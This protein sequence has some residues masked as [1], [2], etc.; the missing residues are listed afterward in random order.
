MKVNGWIQPN[1]NDKK[2]PALEKYLT[3][4]N[5]NHVIAFV[6]NRH[7]C[8]VETL[9]INTFV[10]LRQ[11]VHFQNF[12]VPLKK[13][14]VHFQNFCVPLKKLCVHF[15]NF[16]VPLK[17]LFSLSKLLCSP[18]KTLCSL[19]KLLCSPKKTLCSPLK[20]LCSPKKNFVFTFKAFVFP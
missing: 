8:F 5:L 12:C 9:A 17:K 2:A 20:L 13:L 10:F 14:C 7:N 4:A 6:R 19:S 16:C 3:R 1:S 18:K 15:Q 11:S